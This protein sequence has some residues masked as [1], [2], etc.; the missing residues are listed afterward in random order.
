V[1]IFCGSKVGNN[2]VYLKHAIELGYILAQKNILVV[3]GGGCKGIMGAM[4]NAV[5]ESKGK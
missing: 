4:A 2:P 5:L 3:Y 1:A